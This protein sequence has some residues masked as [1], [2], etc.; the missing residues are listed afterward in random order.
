MATLVLMVKVLHVSSNV[1]EMD[2]ALV[3]E[4]L[5]LDPMR[6]LFIKSLLQE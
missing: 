2:R 5:I 6:H 3:V 1:G 4:R